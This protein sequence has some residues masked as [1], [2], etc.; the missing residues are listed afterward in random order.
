MLNYIY[1]IPV[2]SMNTIRADVRS[3]DERHASARR[4]GHVNEEG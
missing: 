3:I 4:S 1:S 2:T